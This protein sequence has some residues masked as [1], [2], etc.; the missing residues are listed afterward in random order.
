MRAVLAF[1]LL[2]SAAGAPA[3]T[4]GRAFYGTTLDGQRVDQVTLRNARGMTVRIIDYGAIVTDVV[5][6]DSRGTKANVVLGFGNLADYQKHNPDYQ[7]GAVIGRFAGR[8]AGGRFSID[9]RPVQ[10]ARNDGPNSLHGGPGGI[11][12]RVWAMRTFAGKGG[13]GAELT[14]RSPAGDQAFP[15]A[16]DVRVRY[17]LTDDDQLRIDYRAASDAPTVVNLTN[18]SYFNLA[19]A[20]S[21]SVLGHRL[22]L[23]SPQL[24]ETDEHG[25]PSGR[26]LAVAGTPFDFRAAH[27]LGSRIGVAHPQLV[28]RH[29]YNHGW[30][31]GAGGTLRRAGTLTDPISGRA[32]DV[33]TSEPSITIYTAGYMAGK[34]IGAQGTPYRA[35]DGVALETQHVSDSPNQPRWPSTALRPG[36]PFETTTVYR[37]HAGPPAPARL[38]MTIDDL[39][40]HGPIPANETPLSVG[41]RTIAALRTA[42]LTSVM[43]MING[44]WTADQPVTLQV[45]K[46]WRAAG[47]PLGNHTWS[48]LNLNQLSPEQFAA[49]V[50]RNEPLLARLEP[51]GDWHWLRYPFLSEGDDPAKR[52]SARAVLKAHGYKIAAVTTGFDDWAYTAPYARCVA[53][54]DQAGI[55]ELTRLYLQSAEESIRFARTLSWAVEDR[56]IPFVLLQHSGAL[57]SYLLPRLVAIY[58]RNG[59]RFVSLPEAERDPFYARDVDPGLPGP[60]NLESRAAARGIPL[61]YRASVMDRLA[62]ICA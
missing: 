38:A 13:A 47:L 5:V 24:I 60:A 37:F 48:H 43:G 29:G 52:A 23:G 62:A 7:F 16:V 42:G 56:E 51:A 30:W 12:T 41:R 35:F 19:G 32:V 57:D 1:L 22:Q 17:T 49:E 36:K 3:A 9:G 14:V 6:P 31:L 33:S 10:L 54:N 50:A 40:L 27:S 58:R 55:A 61:P 2:A 44:H 8:I 4:V 45:L 11:E 26:L 18:H 28:G 15:G 59:V 34:D 21:G 46:E 20:G 53:K 39:P 25:I